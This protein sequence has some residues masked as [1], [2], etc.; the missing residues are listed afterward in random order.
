M[1]EEVVMWIGIE[2]NAFHPQEK[3]K[4]CFFI[5]AWMNLE[6][7]MLKWRKSEKKTVGYHFYGKTGKLIWE[8]QSGVVVTRS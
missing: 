4:T 2:W 6:S 5:T 8:R 1:G 7:T 3:R